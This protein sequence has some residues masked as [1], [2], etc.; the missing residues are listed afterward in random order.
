MLVS[1]W[2]ETCD[3]RSGWISL[4]ANDNDLRAFATYFIA[5]VERLF[6]GACR[7]TQTMINGPNLPPV[8]DLG[9]T[10]LNE[11]DRIAQPCIIVLDD[12]HLIAETMVHDFLT[13]L[14]KHP[15]QSLHLVI[16]GRQDP[17]LPIFR[18]RAKGLVTEVRANDL[19]FNE[20]E[21]AELLRLITGIQ[22]G[23]HI[24]A[25]LRKQTEGWVTGLYLAAISI[26]LKDNP[27]TT[28]F[29]PRADAQYVMEYLFNEV[30]AKQPPQ[31][32]Q[33]LLGTAVLDR[34]CAP[35][36]EAV[37][38]PGTEADSY[39]NSGWEYISRLKK[40][41]LFLI[42][43]DDEKRWFR[44]HHL[45]QKLLLNQLKRR[46]SAEEINSLHARASAWF[47]DN[48]MVEEA[49]RH[50][51]AAGDERE[52]AK[53][54]VQNRQAAVNA[55]RWFVL[56]KWLSMLPNDII[57]QQPE[58][59]L[60]QAWVHYYHYNYELIPAVR[61][62]AESLLSNH[63]QRQPLFGEINLLKGIV[64][65]FQCDGTRGLKCIE[66]ALEQIPEAHHFIL[67]TADGFWGLA[68]QMQGQK[69]RV[70]N[71]LTD[72]LQKQPLSVARKMRLMLTLVFVYIVS[73]E[74]AVAFSLS[75]HLRN[76]AI[77]KNYNQFIVWSSYFLGLIHFCRNE[78]D[79]AIDYLSQA[80]ESSN[81]IIMRANLDC[82][83][84][85]ALA[86]QAN[87]Q[88][89]TATACIKRLNEYIQSLDNAGF[90]E[91]AH[92][93]TARLALMKGKVPMS[94]GL[95]SRKEPSSAEPMLL[96][97]DIPEITQGRVLLAAGT[98]SDLQKA[99][100]ML[101]ASL[102]MS[103]AQH[104][105]FQRIFILPLLA[106]VYEKQGRLE[107]A[108]TVLEEVVNLAGRGGFIQPFLESG[109]TMASLLKRLAEKNIAADYIGQILAAFSPPTRKPA[110]IAQTP[111]GQLTDREHDVLELVS[112][113]LQTKE[114]AEKL[115]I[116][117]HTVNAHLKSIYRKL[118]A[119]NRREAVEEAKRLKL[120]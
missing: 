23:S 30:F 8:A 57:Q 94:S 96:W 43:L 48:G 89:D 18:L 42:P 1:H 106:S 113:R 34:F 45:F 103:Q 2:L 97:L 81:L 68:G 84:G 59:L 90:L 50:A 66:D 19:C 25:T 109:P 41:N 104:N 47:A 56:E 98:D 15:P 36:C 105:T 35:L 3:I 91:N 49:I 120:I 118:D 101:K 37:C 69:E 44:F 86:Y 79:T 99:E 70:I 54:V 32:S 53:L 62:R 40:E 13:E 78:L 71:R 6:P 55:E 112:Q 116:S 100:N 9:F 74:L 26:R 10:L 46:F 20:H 38:V 27:E 16:I 5:A 93:L 77:S 14:L 85:L 115:F 17:L 60:A 108:L 58:L 22:I 12:Y 39:E 7:K 21:T 65:F 88:T 117:T 61:E 111:D 4:D 95:L 72:L 64:L 107:E 75:Q 82:Q 33:Y 119:H 11:L 63:P 80:A 28:L 114:I 87:Q 73:G 92:S 51:L 102:Q 67:G 83:G 76:Y 24:A 110:S 52:A 31:I 29:E